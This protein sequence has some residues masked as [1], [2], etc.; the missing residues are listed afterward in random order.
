M[1]SLTNRALNRWDQEAR[2]QYAEN[3]STHFRDA[4]MYNNGDGGMYFETGMSVEPG[5]DIHI[6]ILDFRVEEHVP[7][8]VNGY[9]AEVMWCRKIYKGN[10]NAN[11]GVGV[12]F[13]VNVC[14]KC[15]R[16]VNYND[17][18][19]TDSLFFFC[20]T[21]FE[22]YERLDNGKMKECIDHYLMGN[23]L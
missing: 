22:Q 10:G 3:A 18:R 16:K 9:R 14:D 23:V 11:Y 13:M 7:E 15:G 21:C 6:R 17:I 8:A 5:T 1:E 2:I 20:P 12:R 4:V 19:K